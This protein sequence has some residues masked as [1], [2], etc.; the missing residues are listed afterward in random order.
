MKFIPHLCNAGLQN[1]LIACGRCPKEHRTDSLSAAYRNLGGRT[2][3][4]LTQLY[5]RLCT[6]YGL[7]PTRNNRGVAHEN[8]A[9]EASHGHFKNRLY[10]SLLLRG[11]FDFKTVKEYQQFIEQVVAKLNRNCHKQFEHER[12]HL[13]PLP[14]YR[15]ADYEVLTVRVTTRS[16]IHVRCI[17]Y[18]VPSQLI[19]HRLTVHLHHDRLVG[20][21]G[22]SQVVVLPRIHVPADHPIRRA[23]CVNYRHVIDSLRLKPRAFLHCTWQQELLPDDNYCQLWH[24]MTQQFDRYSAARLMTEA[25]YIAA[26]QDKE[27]TVAQ[28]LHQQL[29]AQ[30]LTLVGLQ[31]HFHLGSFKE[32]PAIQVRQH[33]L[34][35]YDQLLSHGTDS[36]NRNRNPQ[37]SLERPQ[38]LSHE[39]TM[40]GVGTPGT[41]AGMDACSISLSPVRTRIDAALSGSHPTSPEGC[42][43]AT[44][45]NTLQF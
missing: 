15:Y 6:H 20:F 34:T 28:Y 38:T 45:K 31:N 30:T 2:E 9:I 36:N 12:S 18:T 17:T 41:T 1:A 16:T 25:L 37:S 21:I 26:T 32:I 42:P 24:Q 39:T 35:H 11:S 22:Q 23:R 8:G 19:G 5:Q 29:E 43:S 27:T 33:H 14:A 40:A 44:C 7:K 13:K 4:D 10:Q 3:S